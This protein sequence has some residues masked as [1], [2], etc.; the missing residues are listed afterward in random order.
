MDDYYFK[1][2]L[3]P[4]EKTLMSQVQEQITLWREYEYLG[5]ECDS[6]TLLVLFNKINQIMEKVYTSVTAEYN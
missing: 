3:L 1:E 2:A 5:T 4:Y 6:R